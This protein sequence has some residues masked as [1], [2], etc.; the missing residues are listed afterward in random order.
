MNDFAGEKID[1]A[2]QEIDFLGQKTDFAD[3]E[4]D[5]LGGKIDF[6]NRMNDFANRKVE[7]SGQ[8]AGS[9]VRTL[10]SVIDGDRLRVGGVHDAA[11]RTKRA[12]SLRAEVNLL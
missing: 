4:V 2:D 8:I 11:D 3:E 9:T 5:F 10:S 1:F 7:F 12:S 6:P